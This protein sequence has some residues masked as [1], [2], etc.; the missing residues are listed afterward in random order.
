MQLLNTL[1]EGEEWCMPQTEDESLQFKWDSLTATTR[2]GINKKT[3]LINKKYTF[4]RC[5]FSALKYFLSPILG[6]IVSSEGTNN[7]VATR[8]LHEVLLLIHPHGK[9]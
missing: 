8:L 7:H 2:S 9:I 6:H 5:P 3:T 4:P 1:V